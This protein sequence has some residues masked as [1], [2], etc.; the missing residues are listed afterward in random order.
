MTA[1]ARITHVAREVLRQG[2]PE[3][4]ITHAAREVLRQ[5]DP[6]VRITRTVR[7]VLRGSV[8]PS[9]GWTGI[10]NGV[11]NP[12]KINGIAVADIAKVCGVE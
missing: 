12:A 1:N 2:D 3:I 5:G 11:T 10:I 4:R 9:T 6:R 7:E 8:A